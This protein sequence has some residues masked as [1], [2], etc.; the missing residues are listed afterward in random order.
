M[1]SREGKENKFFVHFFL[2]RDLLS[3]GIADTTEQHPTPS[4]PTVL[5]FSNSNSKDNEKTM[6]TNESFKSLESEIRINNKPMPPIP[7]TVTGASISELSLALLETVLVDFHF[8]P[9]ATGGVICAP[10]GDE[11]NSDDQ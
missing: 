6:Q 2:M 7:L 1:N 11:D 3:I 4:V 9:R 8:N 5:I 10:N